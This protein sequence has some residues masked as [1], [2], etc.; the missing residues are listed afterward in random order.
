MSQTEE[1]KKALDELHKWTLKICENAGLP[2][3]EGEKLWTDI[4]SYPGLLQEYAYYHDTGD[5]LCQYKIEGF[6]VADILIWQM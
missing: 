6:T 3:A 2:S 5:F 4:Q 1:L